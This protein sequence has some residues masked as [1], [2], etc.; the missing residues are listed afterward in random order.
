MRNSV[1]LAIL[2]TQIPY[3]VLMI[4]RGGWHTIVGAVLAAIRVLLGVGIS[5][6]MLKRENEK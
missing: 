3:V 2:G 5:I 1:R 6:T 4:Y